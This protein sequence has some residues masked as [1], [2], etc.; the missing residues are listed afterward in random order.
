MSAVIAWHA[1]RR[2]P[3]SNACRSQSTRVE[4]LSTD[5]YQEKNLL[6]SEF[7][8]Q[9]NIGITSMKYL[10]GLNGILTVRVSSATG[11]VNELLAY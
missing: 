4:V 10:I 6:F 3:L 9:Y 5:E 8:V 1:F 11:R 2:C 7:S